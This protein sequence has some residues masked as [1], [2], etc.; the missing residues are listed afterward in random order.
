MDEQFFLVKENTPS[1]N[2]SH[3]YLMIF[4]LIVLII[5]MANLFFKDKMKDLKNRIVAFFTKMFS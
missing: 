5:L 4:G 2:V 3:Q 1:L